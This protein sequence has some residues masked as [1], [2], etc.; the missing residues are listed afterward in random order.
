MGIIDKIVKAFIKIKK[1]A[2]IAETDLQCPAQVSMQRPP[3]YQE[4]TS[5][6]TRHEKSR[7]TFTERGK[8]GRLSGGA[9][10]GTDNS[11]LLF[12]RF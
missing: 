9:T 10:M 6:E 4:C 5:R 3:Y 2:R 12:F 7:Q 1:K 11:N 8:A